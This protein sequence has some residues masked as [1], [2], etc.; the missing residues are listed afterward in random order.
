MTFHIDQ[1]M[2]FY[3]TNTFRRNNKKYEDFSQE[4]FNTRV[5]DAMK[6]IEKKYSHK[7]KIAGQEVKTREITA[8]TTAAFNTT[9]N[10]NRYIINS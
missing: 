6:R 4:I 8:T 3:N 9:N 7:N 2:D 10:N 5:Q 1:N